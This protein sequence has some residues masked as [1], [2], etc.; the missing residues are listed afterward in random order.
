MNKKIF[1]ILGII[2]ICIF[3]INSKNKSTI[4]NNTE[5]SIQINNQTLQAANND[6]NEIIEE[7]NNNNLNSVEDIN[8]ID[9]DGTG[10]N[11]TFVYNNESFSAIY[12]TD[13]W[14]IV[15]SY[16]INNSS[17]ILII[18]QALINVHPI[19]GSDII[20]FRTAE[21]MAYEWL[22][23]NLAYELLPDDNSWKSHAKDVDLD[24]EDQGSNLIDMYKSRIK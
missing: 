16:K 24:P 15:D 5:N 22:Q 11:Y 8:L 20:S 17:D 14:H 18:C 19:H 6:N 4:T 12:S 13:N 3:I 2:I 1:I 23:H 7:K 10:K 21:D 9:L